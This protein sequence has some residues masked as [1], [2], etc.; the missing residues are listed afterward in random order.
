MYI[1]VVVVNI[2]I[3]IADYLILKKQPKN[4]KEKK[5]CQKIEKITE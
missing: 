5:S 3:L 4:M 2:L 1:L